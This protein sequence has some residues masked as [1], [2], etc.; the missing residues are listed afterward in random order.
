MTVSRKRISFISIVLV[1]VMLLSSVSVGAISMNSTKTGKSAG[2][3]IAVHYIDVGQGDSILVCLPNGKTVLIDAGNN[4][5]GDVVINYLKSQGVSKID[6][7]IGTHPH[8]DHIG[9]MD[10]VI[11][12][13]SIG[14]VYM[15]NCTTTTKT[16]KDVIAAIEKK[17]LTI[18][19]AKAGVAINL[20][21]NA[22]IAIVAPNV[23]KYSNTNNY[24]AVLRLT[25]G[26]T[27]LLFTGDAEE[28]SENEMLKK[29]C[30]LSANTLK[31][32]HHGSDTATGDAFL[33]AVDPAS[34]VIS[35]GTGN[36][37]GHPHQSTLDKLKAGKV[38]LYRT[39]KNGT[40]V[41]HDNGSAISFETVTT[42][43]AI[44]KITTQKRALLNRS[45][46]ASKQYTIDRFEGN[47]AV[48]EDNNRMMSDVPIKLIPHGS[49]EGDIISFDESG[50]G[51]VDKADTATRNSVAQKLL[52]SVMK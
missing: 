1:C 46:A 48:L 22:K 4:G 14:S 26:S 51:V 30:D 3:E 12:A 50:T 34:A 49:K 8:E 32:G 24:S 2:G 43:S 38:R 44:R 7:I 35:V 25:Y 45:T 5:D 31:V 39:D 19:R 28:L 42:K 13:F 20:D 47:Y 33:A 11:N 37:Y 17:G 41:L 23:D 10:D 16:Y 29:G 27:A 21:S 18:T 6:A 52:N 36:R 15:P 40:V 9:G